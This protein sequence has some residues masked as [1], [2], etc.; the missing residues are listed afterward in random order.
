MTVSWTEEILSDLLQANSH[1]L[2]VEE[3][4]LAV[5]EYYNLRQSDLLSARRSRAVARPRQVAMWLSKQLTTKSFPEI[6]RK[7]GGRDHTTV[8]HGV[9]KIEELREGD[10]VFLEEVERLRRLLGG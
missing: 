1:R 7:F 2:T 8:I 6:G 5:A 3:I 9:R 4:Q 10:S